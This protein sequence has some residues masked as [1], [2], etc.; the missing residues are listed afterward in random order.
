[1]SI[2]KEII[3]KEIISVGAEAALI[4]GE[5]WDNDVVFKLRYPK[6]YRD[7]N[8]DEH[9]RRTRTSYEAKLI[10]E[11]KLKGIPVPSILYVDPFNGLLVLEY[12]KGKK[13]KERLE[14]LDSS[15]SRKI[16]KN[17]GRYV[18]ILHSGGIVHGDLTTSNIVIT[19]DNRVFFIDFGL[20]EFSNELEKQGVDVHLM[21]RALES[22]HPTMVSSLFKAF[23]EGYKSVRGEEWSNKILAKIEEIRL[24]GRYVSRR[25]RVRKSFY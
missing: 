14:G 6:P 24:R 20:G 21:L 11:A 3:V 16:F 4:R 25:R 18:G 9:L 23:V 19:K 10:G 1:M 15:S 12:I 13:L 8:L 2:E 5:M 17:I 7:K 22:T